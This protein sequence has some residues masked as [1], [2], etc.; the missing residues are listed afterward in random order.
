MPPGSQCFLAGRGIRQLDR[1]VSTAAADDPLAVGAAGDAPDA[2]RLSVE[3]Y[4]V[5]LA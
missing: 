3:S 4:G 5:G 2:T 1:L